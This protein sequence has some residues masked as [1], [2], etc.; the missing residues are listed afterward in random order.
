[1]SDQQE[2]KTLKGSGGRIVAKLTPQE[3]K[4]GRVAGVDLFLGAVGRIE[5]KRILQYFC[6]NC[7][8][9]FDGP[10][11]IKYEKLNHE[12]QTAL[13]FSLQQFLKVLQATTVNLQD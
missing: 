12:Y 11:E 5:D 6:K 7:N 9:E 8:K 3:I 13:V 2:E 1:M 10:P 4:K